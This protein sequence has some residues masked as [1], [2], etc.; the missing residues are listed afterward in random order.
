[1]SAAW[2]SFVVLVSAA[3]ALSARAAEW[4]LERRG[5][6][7]RWLWVAAIVGAFVLPAFRWSEA[8]RGVRPALT[9]RS[10]VRLPTIDVLAN[11]TSRTEWG[12]SLDVVLLTGWG[13]ASLLLVLRFGFQRRQLHVAR[14]RWDGAVV[15][16]QR[17]LLSADAGPAAIGGRR[18]A[19]V[20]PRW[21]LDLP[22]PTRALILQHEREHLRA[23]DTWLRDGARLACALAP[24]NPV[25]WYLERRLR[26][27]IEVDCD[28]R[29]LR[30]LPDNPRAY[31]ALLLEV[32][33]RSAPRTRLLP[34]L[35]ESYTL[36]ARRLTIMT[37][38]A[39]PSRLLSFVAS[40]V[41]VVALVAACSSEAPKVGDAIPT[42]VQ[43]VGPF[44]ITAESDTQPN[45]G[46]AYFEFQVETP[47]S[48]AGGTGPRYP[49]AQRTAGQEGEVLAQFIVDTTGRAEVA[50]FKVLKASDAAFA[51]A[52]KNALPDMRFTPARVKG[53]AVR[54]LVQSP[55]SFA[56][57]K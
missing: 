6:A 2:M 24:W 42:G 1:M 28:R 15:D 32:A 48:Y 11:D 44:R 25:L 12:R 31:G 55:F 4:G 22:L 17:V 51:D 40:S 30:A 37:R 49:D 18:P 5:S 8:K 52:V 13:V 34:A 23:G 14:R 45:P 9:L 57:S 21:V 7:I 35:S 20:V 26:A 50:S 39:A 53:R 41:A 16:G 27:A 10:A 56:L 47:A 19:V 3:L 29:V 54:Q 36:I 38:T 43:P 33:G 46:G